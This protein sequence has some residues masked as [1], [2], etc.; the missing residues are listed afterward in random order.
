MPASRRN[1]WC[2]LS[3]ENV[4]NKLTP[5]LPKLCCV[6]L[7]PL[8][9]LSRI[10]MSGLPAP[11]SR[12]YKH[13]VS[14]RTVCVNSILASPADK[15]SAVLL[16]VL[17]TSAPSRLVHLDCLQHMFQHRSVAFIH[18]SLALLASVLLCCF[19]ALSSTGLS[20]LLAEPIRVD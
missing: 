18:F 13:E 10:G 4:N 19:A 3:H 5:T 11:A 12:S 6:A 14:H 9:A 2:C 16:C 20:E 7:L 15:A 8:L 1:K 17:A